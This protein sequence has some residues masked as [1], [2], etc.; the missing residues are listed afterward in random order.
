MLTAMIRYHK[1]V[2]DIEASD[3]GGPWKLL[4]EETPVAGM[5]DVNARTVLESLV[6]DEQF[7]RF[8][9]GSEWYK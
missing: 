7:G 1:L 5:K 8:R 6:N 9:A 3:N 2:R 4:V